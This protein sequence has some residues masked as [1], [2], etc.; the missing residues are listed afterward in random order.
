MKIPEGGNVVVKFWAEWCGPC[1]SLAPVYEEL[2]KENED[3]EFLSVNV[4][5]EKELTEKYGIRSL[6]SVI[7]MRN[8]VVEHI[9]VGAKSKI[10]MQERVNL[11]LE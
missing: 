2:K 7:F 11:L 10:D 5:E 3:I 4:D 6:P 8:G 9:L 1:R